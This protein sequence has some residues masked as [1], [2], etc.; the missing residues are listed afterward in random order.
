MLFVVLAAAGAASGQVFTVL[1]D[2]PA[3]GEKWMQP[4]PRP[5]HGVVL[6]VDSAGLRAQLAHAPMLR[7]DAPLATYGVRLALPWPS[8]AMVEC[9]VAESPVMEPALQ[10]RHPAMRTYIVQSLDAMATGRLEVTPRGVTAMLRT[11]GDDP[12]GSGP[13]GVWMIDLWRTGDPD[14]AVAYWLRDLTTKGTDWVCETAE[15][16]AGA[17]A[18]ATPE[19]DSVAGPGGGGARDIQPLRTVRLAMACTGEWGLHQCAVAGHEPNT[20]DPLAAIVTLVGRAN[21]VYEADLAVHF[22]LV[23]NND[24]IVYVDPATDPYPDSC[25]GT[26]GA[27]CSG[28]YLQPNIDNLA[29]VIGNDNFEIGHLLTRVF[30]GV[31]YLQSVCRN[32]RAG[33]ISGI[34]RGGDIDPFTMLV[35]I[36]EMGHQ[37]GANHTFSGTRGRCQGNVH[38]ST[39]WEAGSG[40]S[41]MAYAGG[42]PVG[43][44]PPSDNIVQFADP[45][46]HHGSLR[47]A[48]SFLATIS[49]PVQTSS[50]N[51]IPVIESATGD[52][53]IPP[54][55]PFVLN[56]AATDADGDALT[57]SWEEY[58]SGVARPL[59][60]AGSGDSGEGAL[61]RVFT[62]V[63]VG[64]RTFPQMSDILSGVPTP[65]EQLPAV[66]GVTRRFRVI[67]R[68]NHP[69]AGGIAISGFTRLTLPS[70]TSAFG[71]LTPAAGTMLTPGNETEVTWTVGGT[72]APPISCSSVTIRLSTDDGA[73]FDDVLGTFPNNGIAM[74][75]LPGTP[76]NAAR[77]RIDADGQIFFAVSGA[78]AIGTACPADFNSDGTVN[79]QD[80]F[81]FLDLFFAVD[82]GADFNADGVID[83]QDFFDFLAAFFSPGC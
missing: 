2:L 78:F 70:G 77:I 76:S 68:D 33:G 37:F 39:A 18:P 29:A 65:G 40:S 71:V 12:A 57:Y 3:P 15:P 56:A 34:P 44:E 69:G 48:Q 59:S 21:V 60:G 45:F 35:A 22:N 36:H 17:A 16:A 6:G 20:D 8:G 5:D 26:G 47:E 51:N 75:T 54:S 23:A 4:G 80:F 49:C 63:D 41:P 81:E 66:T 25:D 32:S 79:S 24:Q 46:F 52:S 28:P 82:A 31:A 1:P 58:D 30:G 62:P 10:A 14:H 19:K 13:G 72:D 64:W 61:F 53:Y 7:T 11:V 83:S 73:T 43:D 38:L 50:G 55:T 27:D 9:A 67:V 74:V 42:C